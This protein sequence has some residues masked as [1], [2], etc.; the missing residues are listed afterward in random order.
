MRD[1]RQQQCVAVR[2]TLGDLVRPD[3]RSGARLVVD[4]DRLP[5]FP[6]QVDGQRA[7]DEVRAPSAPPPAENGTMILMGFSG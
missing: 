1:R 6:G 4:D 7:G 2:R 5:Q 3:D